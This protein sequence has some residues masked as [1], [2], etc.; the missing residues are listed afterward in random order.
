VA[1]ERAYAD[2]ITG[3]R[4]A[5]VTSGQIYVGAIPYVLIQI[6]MVAIVLAFPGLVTHY[7]SAR[8]TVDPSSVEVDVQQGPGGGSPFGHPGASPFG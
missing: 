7:K 1:P 4:I 5:P 8:A 6:V 2:K 3:R